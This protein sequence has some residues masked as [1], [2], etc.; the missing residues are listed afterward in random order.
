MLISDIPAA[1]SGVHILGSRH[2]IGVQMVSLK[3]EY[4][5]ATSIELSQNEIALS[6]CYGHLSVER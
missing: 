6:N 1:Q 4:C 2:A 5:F 3:G